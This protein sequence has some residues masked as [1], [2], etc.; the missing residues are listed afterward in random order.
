[1]TMSTDPVAFADLQ[2]LAKL[3]GE[4]RAEGNDRSPETLRKVAGQFEALF[5]QMMLK[6]M[7]ESSLNEGL[8]ESDQGKLYQ[9]MF[10][11]QIAGEITKGKGLGLA[12]ILIRQL[13]G[14]SA[15]TAVTNPTSLKTEPFLN[16]GIMQ[17]R[18][19]MMPY[20]SQATTLDSS[21]EA[22]ASALN[23]GPAKN[24]KP[25]SREDF[26][27]ELWP[28]AERAAQKLGVDPRVL[29]AQAA[30]ESGWG[31]HVMQHGN[32]H[33][34]N[35][36]FGIKADTRWDGDQVRAKTMEFRNG[37][38]AREQAAFRAYA[39]PAESM[40]DYADFISSNP[41]YQD[42][43]GTADPQRY[44]LELQRAGY[45]TDPAYAHKIVSIL[46][47]DRFQDAVS[48]AQHRSQPA[49]TEAQGISAVTQS[50]NSLI[51]AAPNRAGGI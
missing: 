16:S 31:Q 15:A 41:R 14:D 7:R 34:S 17:R 39:S 35:N 46:T 26:V 42:A 29:V 5:V 6:N 37:A 25:D 32:G 43:I 22:A 18:G 2:G 33:S 49:A 10:D 38:L 12:D 1:M 40:A 47:N 3:R 48:R 51:D 44:A 36:L 4:V 50:S 27:T 20:V 8:L 23:Y 11:Q 45:A 21:M 19:V 24:W 13:G 9:G 28:H 30:L